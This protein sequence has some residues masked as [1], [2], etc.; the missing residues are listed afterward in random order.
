M[1]VLCHHKRKLHF[2]FQLEETLKAFNGRKAKE[3]IALKKQNKSFVNVVGELQGYGN[4]SEENSEENVN[5]DLGLFFKILKKMLF[6]MKEDTKIAVFFFISCLT[7]IVG[8]I[9]DFSMIWLLL[10]TG[11]P[12]QALQLFLSKAN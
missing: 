6:C 7:G 11:F 4:E 9:S 8:L 3:A 5:Y 12:Y 10:N 2:I 1:R